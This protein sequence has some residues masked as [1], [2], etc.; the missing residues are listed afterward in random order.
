MTDVMV[1]H[2]WKKEDAEE[3]IM[4]V[5][6]IVEMSKKGKLPQGFNLKSVDVLAGES[7][8][9]CRWEAPSSAALASLIEKVDPPTTHKVTDTQK[10]F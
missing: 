10:V 6:N 1:E 3:V 2:V 7:K 5:G 4:V 8:A 9:I